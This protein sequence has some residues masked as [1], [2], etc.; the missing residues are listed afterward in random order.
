MLWS[1]H[2]AG[3][4][5]GVL[6]FLFS[7]A[8][9]ESY[10]NEDEE[11][12]QPV[13]KTKGVCGRVVTFQRSVSG[14]GRDGVCDLGA[15]RNSDSPLPSPDFLS[16]HGTAWDPSRE[17]TSLGEKCLEPAQLSQTGLT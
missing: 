3:V 17:A 14:G 2:R 4:V 15:G 5:P 6:S 12:A 7:P 8:A 11:L 1:P 16:P 13:A 9:S 10:E